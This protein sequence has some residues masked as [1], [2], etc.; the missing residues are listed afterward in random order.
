[1]NFWKFIF[2]ILHCL[3][4]YPYHLSRH[5][6]SP[7]PN[8]ACNTLMDRCATAYVLFC[9]PM[10]VFLGGRTSRLFLAQRTGYAEFL[11]ILYS[12]YLDEYGC[13]DNEYLRVRPAHD[14]VHSS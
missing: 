13:D 11:R 8:T 7:A 1:M 2:K 3:P 9:R 5:L 6:H 14:A 10:F 4:R 12:R